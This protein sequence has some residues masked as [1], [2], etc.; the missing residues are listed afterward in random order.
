MGR[1]DELGMRDL[2]EVGGEEERGEVCRPMIGGIR[3]RR[4]KENNH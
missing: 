3:I 2:R 4:E 1:G